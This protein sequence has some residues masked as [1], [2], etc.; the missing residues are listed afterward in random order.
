[1]KISMRTTYRSKIKSIGGVVADSHGHFTIDIVL[2]DGTKGYYPNT[3]EFLNKLKVG[4]EVSYIDTKEFAGRIKI[5]GLTL[6]EK[7]KT[8]SDKIATIVKLAGPL[9]KSDKGIYY[10]ELTTEDGIT[11]IF[12]SK[13]LS[14]V[15]VI[16]SGSLISYTDIIEK[17]GKDYF[18]GLE[19][20]RRHS[21]D[22]K[23]QLSIIRQAAVKAAIECI[24]IASPKGRW[25]NKDGSVDEESCFNEVTSLADLFVEYASV[26]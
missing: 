25:V 14:E 9:S 6:I 4:S 16:I 21:L 5:N 19:K 8:M 1:M 15:E 12:F 11:A 13:E 18:K 7:T 3:E 2:E 24:A 23:R 26:E 10:K 22:D 17:E 20:L